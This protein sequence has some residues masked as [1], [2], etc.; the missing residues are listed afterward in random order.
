MVDHDADATTPTGDLRQ[1][2]VRGAG[3][4]LA[5][6]W[7]GRIV[8][9]ATFFLLARLLAPD[10][11]G[12]V[13][14]ATLVIELGQRL[15]NRGFGAA[16]VQR[17]EVTRD[18]LD[19]AFWFSLG[20]GS[21]LTAI[22]WASA[23]LVADLV[24]EPTFAP[25]LRV[26]SINWM[27]SAFWV[28]PQN[29]L[30][31]ELR[32]AGLTVRRLLSV[33][34]SGAVAVGLALAGA[35]VWSLV[36]M[37]LVQ[38]VVSIV[39]LWTVSS[40]RP[41]RRFSRASLVSM[42]GYASRIVAIEFVGFFAVRGEGLL[43]GVV[44]GPASLGFYAVA[45]RFVI[46]L[47]EVFTAS[48]GRVAFPVFSRLQNQSE[49]RLRALRSVIRLT[50]LLAF[51]AF[52]G[53]AVLAPELV[54]VL[55]GPTWEP[56]VI[57]IQLLAIHGLRS[58]LSYFVSS[59]IVSTGDAALQLRVMLI[60][61]CVKAI[62]LLIGIQYGATGVAWAVVI[63]SYLTLP[64]TFWA[65]RRA[66]GLTARSYLRQT[67]EPALASAAMVGA[68]LAFKWVVGGELTDLS[69]LVLGSMVGVVTYGLTIALIRPRLLSEIRDVLRDLGGRRG[70][71][72][73]SGETAAREGT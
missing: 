22:S 14:L 15:M 42:R 11:F 47:N 1:A 56:S 34:I 25:V 23:D 4:S 70:A 13:A 30:Q 61:V 6:A 8:S 18:D 33:T 5:S 51:P 2:A 57:L 16:I 29:V 19:A 43:V 65:L 62:A 28:V 44:L 40:W 26:L 68:V 31:R 64:L 24:G 27:L 45:Q 55:L 53:L 46:F 59:V 48:I 50:S 66:T 52:A 35:G 49:R 71:R 10:E 20:V 72:H 21:L 60:G 7:G 67:L 36:A 73:D 39:V 9:T 63:S 58:A 37:S 17:K 3:W 54:A 12:I 41:S 32:F 69:V 38:S